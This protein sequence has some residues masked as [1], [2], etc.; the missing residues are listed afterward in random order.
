MWTFIMRHRLRWIWVDYEIH[1]I[2]ILLFARLKIL[3]LD[4]TGSF[5]PFYFLLS[6]KELLQTPGSLVVK[7]RE[8]YVRKLKRTKEVM[9]YIYSLRSNWITKS[10]NRGSKK[11]LANTSFDWGRNFGLL[12]LDSSCYFELSC[13]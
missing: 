4:G 10:L 3:L 11:I 13:N 12:M 1:L 8:W 2:V 7:M 5:S 9:Q 6:L